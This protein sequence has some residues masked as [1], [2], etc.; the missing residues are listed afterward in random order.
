MH[1]LVRAHGR[2]IA[3]FFCTTELTRKLE[4]IFG[5]CLPKAKK[6]LSCSSRLHL[7][8]V[9][10]DSRKMA[11]SSFTYRKI[12]DEPRFSFNLSQPLVIGGRYQ[13]MAGEHPHGG[14][15]EKR[16]FSCQRITSLS[17]LM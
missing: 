10:R 17:L 4:P 6:N 14:A 12:R 1:R 7:M 3:G 2:R 8:K 5:C 11:S 16:S 13:T 9:L 15:M